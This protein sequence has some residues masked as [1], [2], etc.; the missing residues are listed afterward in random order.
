MFKT[1]FKQLIT[2]H[3]EDENLFY[4]I[5]AFRI[6]AKFEWC[7]YFLF[8]KIWK[9]G[10][11][12]I[13][14][15]SSIC[16]SSTWATWKIKTWVC[17]FKTYNKFTVSNSKLSN[18]VVQVKC[19]Y[20]IVCSPLTRISNLNVWTKRTVLINFIYLVKRLFIDPNLYVNNY[21]QAN[22]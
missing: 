18:T 17:W 6:N 21:T 14:R 3:F 9:Y 5:P 8:C 4:P 20:A 15:T 13:Y 12:F 22:I 7:F 16:C 11:T 19:A 10:T 2:V 1:I